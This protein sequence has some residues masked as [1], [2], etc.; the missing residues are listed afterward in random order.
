[1]KIGHFEFN[2]PVPDIKESHV[3]AVLRP[4]IDVGG[5]GTLSLSRL[6]RHLRA[7]E[8]G[9]L[10]SP[11]R[12]Y[13][14]TR[15]R[16]RSLMNEGKREFNVPNTIIRHAQMSEGPDLLLVHL[17]EPH[18]YGEEYVETMLEV[19]EYLGVKKYSLVGAMYDMVPHTR[20]L[21]VSGVG[22]GSSIDEEN[23][24]MNVKTSNY[25]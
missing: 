18:L 12:F 7:K 11:G 8:I 23:L 1:M 25:E 14:F 2:E 13:D 22:V 19:F 5:V 9:R 17:L 20:P 21:I 6:E 4:W 16:P 24:R 15:Y 3:L 10:E